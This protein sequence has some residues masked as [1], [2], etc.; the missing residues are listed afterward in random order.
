[1][2]AAAAAPSR[3]ERWLQNVMLALIATLL[4]W[5]LNTLKALSLYWAL[6]RSS[7]GTVWWIMEK[8]TRERTQ[9]P[10]PSVTASTVSTGATRRR[11]RPGMSMISPTP[12]AGIA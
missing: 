8:L 1:M 11:P 7:A 10:G 2:T 5:M 9:R 3:T 4:G 6:I 12:Q